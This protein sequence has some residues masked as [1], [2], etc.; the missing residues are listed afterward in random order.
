MYVEPLTNEIKLYTIGLYDI[1]K[2]RLILIKHFFITNKS[3]N[4]SHSLR[5]HGLIKNG[6]I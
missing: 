5:I 3:E 6:S 1:E 4:M 2:A